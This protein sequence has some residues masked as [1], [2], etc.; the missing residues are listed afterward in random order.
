VGPT[1]IEFFFDIMCPY[2]YQTSKW[3]RDI[4]DQGRVDVTWRFFSLEEI[5]LEPGKRHP[6]ERPWSFGF[7]M[8]RVAALL[9]RGVGEHD[10]NDLVDRYYSVAGR[11]LHEE[12]RKPHSPEASQEILA[13]LDLDPGLVVEAIDDPTT[14]DEVRSD[15]DSLVAAGGFGVPVLVVPSGRM[16]FGPVVAPAPEGAAAAAL[17]SIVE[18]AESTEHFYELKRV[19]SPEDLRHIGETF[20]PYLEGRDWISVERPAP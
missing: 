3:I 8:L 7:G 15:H 2:A 12:G 19:K 9:R 18:A 1:P 16:W 13:S 11:W 14:I 20:R 17:W 4:R 10:G 6:W 5:N